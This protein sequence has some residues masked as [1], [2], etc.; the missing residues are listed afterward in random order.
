MRTTKLRQK[1]VDQI[2]EIQKRLPAPLPVAEGIRDG[3]YRLTPDGPGDE[4][5]PGKGDRFDYGVRVLL[6]AC[7]PENPLRYRRSISAP[8]AWTWPRTRSPLLSNRDT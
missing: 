8:T 6:S 7:N 3:D 4:P 2:E 5:L 1:L